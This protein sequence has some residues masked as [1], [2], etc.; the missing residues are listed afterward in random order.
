MPNDLQSLLQPFTQL[1]TQ[2]VQAAAAPL[3]QMGIA[4]PAPPPGPA[5]VMSQMLAGVPAIPGVPALPGA[6]QFTQALKGIEAALPPF[7]PKLTQVIPQGG[8]STSNNP[9][10][11]PGQADN[12]Y[13][14][15][16]AQA[17]SEVAWEGTVPAVP[18]QARLRFTP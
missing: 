2:V 16:R 7:L 1:E 11:N 17:P 3:K 18:R 4:L 14:K 8:G 13:P 10:G 15:R 5:G 9:R 12:P 6:A